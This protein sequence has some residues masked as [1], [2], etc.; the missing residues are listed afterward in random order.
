MNIILIAA[1]LAACGGGGGGETK[2]GFG[3]S[4]DPNPLADVLTASGPLSAVGVAGIGTTGLDDRASAIFIN[5]Q[6]GQPFSALKL[7]MVA[8]VTGTIPANSTSAMAGAATNI[9]VQSAVVGPVS[10]VDLAN[11]RI[12]VF[13]LTVQIDQNTI[14]EGVNSLANLRT[15]GRVEVYGLAQPESGSVLATRLIS[16]PAVAAAPIE[17]LGNA[18]NVS[19]FQFTLQGVAVSTAS[20]AGVT[21]PTGNLSGTTSIVEN[22]RVRVLG[23]Y[24]ATG[25]SIVPSQIITGIPV[26]R[27]DNTITVLDGV[28]QSISSNGRIRLNDTDVETT[29]A[30]AAA[31]SVGSRLQVKGRKTAGI[32]VATDFR[33]I[34]AGER[35]QY[36][37]QGEI[38]NFVSVA[39]FTIRGETINASAATFIGG[40]ATNLANSRTVRVKV[41]AIAGQLLASEVSFV[42][43]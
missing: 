39:N 36:V 10:A 35:I 31:V 15:G 2:T 33:L 19:A 18:T 3:G 23:T 40:A 28:V 21:T 32:V 14:F 6:G 5:T 22:T 8:E 30:N 24:T 13:P 41:Q 27:N 9:L 34:A 38:A 16:P 43:S 37:V 26:T 4:G 20:I 29:A 11:Q 12:I 7:G 17:L 25:N 42:G 1:L